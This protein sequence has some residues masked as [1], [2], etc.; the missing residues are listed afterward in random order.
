M[1]GLMTQVSQFLS[2]LNGSNKTTTLAQ[3]DNIR[4]QLMYVGG[5]GDAYVPFTPAA[6]SR[7]LKVAADGTL[8]I[9]GSLGSLQGTV[10]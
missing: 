3:L 8:E 1:P 9:V 7:G 2:T 4:R 10:Q 6:R 5:V